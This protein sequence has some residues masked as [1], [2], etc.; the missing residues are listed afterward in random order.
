VYDNGSIL[1]WATTNSPSSSNVTFFPNADASTVPVFRFSANVTSWGATGTTTVNGRLEVN[2]GN[3]LTLAGTGTKTFRN[4]IDGAGS[5]SQG[6]AGQIIISGASARLGGGTLTLGSSGI[7]VNSGSVVTVTSDKTLAGTGNVSNSGT[8]NLTGTGSLSGSAASG[9]VVG[10]T[11]TLRFALGGQ[12]LKTLTI[13]GGTSTLAS[14]L[15]ISGG[16]ASD[17]AGVVTVAS[18]A[19]LASDGNLTIQSNAFGT[20]RVA[21]GS[22]SGNY[23]TGNVTVERYVPV[24][25][26]S[27]AP[28]HMKAW[29]LLSVPTYVNGGRS[30]RSAWQE[31]G[32]NTNGFGVQITG[33]A[34]DAL[35]L[36]FDARTTS[37]SMQSYTGTSWVSVP[38]TNNYFLDTTGAYFIFI[39]GNRTVGTTTAV[40]DNSKDAVLRTTGSLYQGNGFSAALPTAFSV[41]GNI[42]PSAIDF[43][44]LQSGNSA[45]INEVFYLWDARR[46]NGTSLGSYQTFSATND[47]GCTPGGGSFTL[48]QINT[49]IQSGQG[50][51]VVSKSPGTG[52]RLSFTENIKVSGSNNKALRPVIPA[53]QLVKIDTRLLD[54][55][56]GEVA[57]GNTVVF[58]GRYANAVDNDD[59]VKLKNSEE[60]FGIA[61]GS[62]LLAVE[63]RQPV[64]DGDEIVFASGN[65]KEKNYMLEV[66]AQHLAEAGLEAVLEDSYTSARTPLDLDGTTVVPVSVNAND[67][68]KAANRFKIVFSRKPVASVKP[69]FTVSPNPVSEGVLNLRLLNQAAGRYQLRLMAAD[70]KV[71]MQQA[72]EHAGG[73]AARQL[74]LPAKI[75]AGVYTLE[76][77]GPDASR[78]TLQVLVSE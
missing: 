67:N 66:R 23:I 6:T 69:S 5:L 45:K 68:S 21:Q 7:A 28:S 63:G 49:T 30:I 17:A 32:N 74:P 41:I 51:F 20:A 27:F 13:N 26:A 22:T 12:L 73:T 62:A 78:Q 35:S 71:M 36:G 11:S 56:N 75:S 14:P 54:A 72:L 38:N 60:N 24:Y 46:R 43:V 31:G 57:D 70:G 59:A 3:S 61:R 65:L 37:T 8:I 44:Q 52:D 19:A 9:L 64:A 77:Y 48:N 15:T 4:G 53:G 10:A 18:G 40:T 50:F 47:Y 1:E 16:T 2:T 25:N 42:Y 39:R 34:N 33:T 55:G 58:A 76:L 29:R